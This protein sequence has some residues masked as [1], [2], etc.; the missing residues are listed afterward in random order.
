MHISLGLLP[1]PCVSV[2]LFQL[3]TWRRVMLE[4]KLR[5]PW[6]HGL[7]HAEVQACLGLEGDSLSVARLPL[8]RFEARSFGFYGDSEHP[9]VF[10]FPNHNELFMWLKRKRR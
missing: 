8:S 1:L 4:V 10:V 6:G 3:L 9:V 2:P 5:S 7:K